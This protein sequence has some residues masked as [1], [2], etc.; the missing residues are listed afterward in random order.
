MESDEP[1]EVTQTRLWVRLL[2][3]LIVPMLMVLATVLFVVW[4]MWG[5]AVAGA[6][7]AGLFV[8]LRSK[9]VLET[10]RAMR[11]AA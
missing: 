9:Q 3:L 1:P 6:V 7:I 2:L 11:Q 10:S 4:G 5:W 8:V